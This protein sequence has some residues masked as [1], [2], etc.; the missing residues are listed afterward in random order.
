MKTHQLIIFTLIVLILPFSG[1]AQEQLNHPKR[2]YESPEGKIYIQ[3]S[4]PVYLRIATS[5]D[6][7]AESYLLESEE[8]SEYSNPMFFDTEGWNT[9]RSPSAVDTNSKQ[10]VY[11]LQD[12]IFEVYADSRAPVT[13]IKMP[14]ADQIRDE[15]K[16]YF[17]GEVEISL[18]ARDALSG[19]EQI[20]YSLD[21]E[22]YKPYTDALRFDQEKE[23]TLKYY[24]VD[25]VRNVEKPHTVSFVVDKTSP[26]TSYSIEGDNKD[27]ILGMD[28]VIK[29]SSKDSLSGVREIRY[30]INGADEQVYQNPI[31]VKNFQEDNNELVYYAVDN[32]NNIEDK[33]SLKSSVEKETESDNG[34][35]SFSY[36]IDRDAPTVELRIN[37]DQFEGEKLFV[38]ERSKV[39]LVAQDDKSGVKKISYSINNS[40]LSNVYEKPFQLNEGG[41]LFV[42]Y[43]AEDQVNNVSPRKM[44]AL[45]NDNIAPKSEVSYEGRYYQ[46]RDT[47]FVKSTTRFKFSGSDQ[48]SGLKE[49]L[50]RV[51]DGEFKSYQDPVSIDQAGM[52]ILSY[53]AVDQVN[54]HEKDQSLK[55]FVDQSAPEIYH[56]FSVK[57]IGSKTIRDEEYTIYPSNSRLYI[58]ATDMACGTDQLRYRINDGEW[59]SRIPIPGFKPG[60]YQVEIQ[61]TDYLGNG[62]SSSVKFAIEH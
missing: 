13:S 29:L 23:Y 12:I 62:S 35:E 38:S 40:T 43:A 60:N 31:S 56:H 30:S 49:I 3:K 7:D 16:K 57:S 19:L 61:A 41:A 18:S 27:N 6:E 47:V 37:G 46:N 8:S 1:I 59:K 44:Q 39:E 28:A 58:A 51:D 5:P 24:S 54:N 26:Q 11:P 25:N 45:F 53:H 21:G 15:G 10:L 34:G 33:Q 52:H 2:I 36:Y 48:E 20:Y 42:N 14:K 55:I 9:V 4:L 50:C 17:N 22:A 32:V